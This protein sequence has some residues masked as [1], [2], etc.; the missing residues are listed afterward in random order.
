MVI[1]VQENEKPKLSEMAG[2]RSCYLRNSWDAA[3]DIS[4]RKTVIQKDTCIPNVYCSTTYSGSNLG[5]HRQ[6]DG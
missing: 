6:M 5:I 1:Y 2:T 3:G 4:R